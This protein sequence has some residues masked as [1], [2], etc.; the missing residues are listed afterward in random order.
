[1]NMKVSFSARSET[2]KVRSNN[3][4]N[5]YCN[6]IIMTVPAR[7][8]PF[9]LH[10]MTEIPCMF[11]VCDGMGGEDCGE[12]ASITAVETL[13]AHEKNIMHNIIDADN[14]IQNFVTDAN[15]RLI[16]IMKERRIRMGTTLALA[17]VKD[18]FFSIYNLGDSRVYKTEKGR[19]VRVTDD[20]TLA[21]DK[22]RM[23]LI[24]PKK[25]EESRERH[26]LMRFLGMY[27]DEII[28][29]PDINGP[30]EINSKDRVLL[31]SDGLTEMLSYKN[32]ADIMTNAE[33]VSDAVN[34]LV[35]AAL[36]N[37]GRDNVTCIV[38]EFQKGE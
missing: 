27:D 13:C 26:I 9:F 18:S 6:G 2:G 10:G 25:A 29:S 22:M 5:L 8:R 20:H 19:L 38:L 35:D 30:F 23:G 28:I 15:T 12:L 11:A 33:N 7:S 37:G 32:I 17:V 4:D 16:N 31:C 3:E 34:N 1:M 24:T 36:F 14:E 21:E